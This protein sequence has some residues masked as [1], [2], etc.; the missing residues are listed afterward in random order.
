MSFVLSLDQGT[1][2]SRSIVF[3]PRTRIR[4]V[5]Q[6]EFPQIYPSPGHVEHDPEAIWRTQLATARAALKKA[7]ITASD[8]AAI[9]ITNQRE[10]VVLW[11]RD[12]G[13]PVDNAIVWQS[14]ITAPMCDRLKKAGHEELVRAKTGLVIDA[15]FSGTKIRHLLDEH[16]LHRRAARGEILAGTIDTFLLWRLT[17]GAVHATDY[18]N[19]SRTLL[20]DIHALDWDPQ[21]LDLL[22]VPREMLP[23]VRDSSGLFGL[24]TKK[25]LGAAVPIAGV[26]G[27][28]QAA[29]FG[30]GCFKKGMV[31]NTYGTGCFLLMNTGEQAVA[32]KSGL[33]TTIGWGIG[34]K[35]TYC[36]EGSVF[37]GGAAVQWLRDGLKMLRR[38]GDVEKLAASVPDSGGVYFVPAFVG[39][40]APH[41]DPYARGLIIGIERSTTQGHVARATV[42]SMAYQSHDLVRAMEADSGVRLKE[43]RVDGGAAVNDSLMQFQADLLGCRVRRPKVHETTALGAA[44][45]AG[46]ATGVWKSQAD[47][48]ANWALDQE[49]DPAT[50]PAERRRLVAAW[51]SAVERSKGWASPDG[52]APV[53]PA[54]AGGAQ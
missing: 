34:G 32:S 39:L 42:D 27:D 8:L 29:T 31:K 46:L 40:G 2:S 18:S 48:A 14:R 9:G 38:S 44:Y 22:G 28:Q 6:K 15:Y 37:I 52:P 5:A 11:E 20:F 33:L 25:H 21:L 7:G 36:L 17:D 51:Q 41:W 4:G 49:F 1:T 3:D 47:V 30:Q 26:A 54:S 24:S 19:A 12:T 13:K 43:L 50:K 10:T 35:V 23:E 45:L 16:K 53:A